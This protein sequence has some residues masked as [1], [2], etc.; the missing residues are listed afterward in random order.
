MCNTNMLAEMP[1]TGKSVMLNIRLIMKIS[2]LE[3]K[4]FTADITP[5]GDVF[6]LA[7]RRP[8]K[9]ENVFTGKQTKIEKPR[10]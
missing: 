8:R 2:V 4:Y 3:D 5:C 10:K 1:S 9:H 7:C 6:F